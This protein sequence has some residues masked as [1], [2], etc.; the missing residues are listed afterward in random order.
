MVIISFKH[1]I[2]LSIGIK[3]P[4]NILKVLL[5]LLFYKWFNWPVLCNMSASNLCDNWGKRFSNIK[6]L[7]KHPF[8][9][10]S[11]EDFTQ[12][13]YNLHSKYKLSIP[14]K[15]HIIMDHVGDYIEATNKGL[16]QVSDQIVEAAHSA[17]NKRLVSSNYWVKDLESDNHGVKLYR[18]ILHFNSYNIWINP[19][20]NL[21]SIPCD[22]CTKSF[23]N[24]I[25][26]KYHFIVTS[27]SRLFK[28]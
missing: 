24:S 28:R 11:I 20:L 18:C 6:N 16:G 2:L 19:C 9:R 22:Q 21:S 15:V 4:W 17:L 12:N 23:F 7:R 14:N 5:F 26:E 25:T 27:A 13:W 1:S 3:W 8:W 10:Q